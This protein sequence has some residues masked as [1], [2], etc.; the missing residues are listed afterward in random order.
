MRAGQAPVGIEGEGR[1]QP[2]AARA[3]RATAGRVSAPGMRRSRGGM[4]VDFLAGRPGKEP[5]RQAVA[6]NGMQNKSARL[7]SVNDDPSHLSRKAWPPVDPGRK[8]ARSNV[9]G[10]HDKTDPPPS[11]L[12]GR[13]A[14]IRQQSRRRVTLIAIS[15]SAMG[16]ISKPSRIMASPHD[17]LTAS[18][19]PATHHVAVTGPQGPSP[20][21]PRTRR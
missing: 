18:Q 14:V 1:G 16:S 19:M 3:F 15:G 13:S 2:M 12:S 11:D 5:G 4:E 10:T 8:G 6:P 9:Q 7:T 17:S 21:S 20:P